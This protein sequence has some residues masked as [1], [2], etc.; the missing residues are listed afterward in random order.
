MLFALLMLG[1]A[2]DASDTDVA[3]TDTDTDTDVADTDTDTDVADTDTGSATTD[4]GT[5]ACAPAEVSLGS[6]PQATVTLEPSLCRCALV[7]VG[8]GLPGLVLTYNEGVSY[9]QAD[10]VEGW[11]IATA[12][13]TPA[14][15][16]FPG[17]ETAAGIAY[18]SPYQFRLAHPDGSQAELTARITADRRVV[19]EAMSWVAGCP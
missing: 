9:G 6:P 8:Q 4:T 11:T 5:D 12:T 19:L 13:G 17:G 14:P 15:T 18:D 10:A 3:D 7:A 1:C 16:V 2:G